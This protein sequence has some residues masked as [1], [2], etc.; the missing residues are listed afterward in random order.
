MKFDTMP[1]RISSI[2]GLIALLAAFP[3]FAQINMVV[4]DF[5]DVSDWSAFGTTIVTDGNIGTITATPNDWGKA[6]MS[7]WVTAE[8]GCGSDSLFVN[9]TAVAGHFKINIME[10]VPPY[11]EITLADGT[12]P[13][14]YAA[15]VSGLTGWTGQRSFKLVI[16]VEW[17]TPG[18]A[19]FDEISL[20]NTSGW[21]DDFDP[22]HA[23]WRDENSNPG[24][25]AVF[26]DIGGPYANVQESPGVAW[27][28]VLSPVL[29]INVD[30]S[31]T[32]TAVVQ[33][34]EILSNFVFG[35]QQETAPWAYYELG[36]G[37]DA[38]IFV[39]DYAAITGWSGNQT[40]SIMLGVESTDVDGWA[41]FDSIKLDCSQAP[42]P[43]SVEED[44]SWGSIKEL[45]R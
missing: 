11:T 33:S 1:I 29:T 14:L 23:G 28:K 3:A 26:T 37:Y 10:E 36:R 16:W 30:D 25:N 6:E 15:D 27:G 40:F 32:L 8:F 5:A 2:L 7:S 31:P 19:S 21:A 41:T 44:A 45:F 13:G 39:Y 43:T 34:D 42:P 4:E 35:I 20:I 12:G 22:A 24:F 9:C 17:D 38:G 18:S